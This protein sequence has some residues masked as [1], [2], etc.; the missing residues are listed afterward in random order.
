[1]CGSVQV[2]L[3][4]A[5]ILHA[6]WLTDF[7]TNKN[8]LDKI[9]TILYL[10]LS[11]WL[12]KIKGKWQFID[13]EGAVSRNTTQYTIFAAEHRQSTPNLFCRSTKDWHTCVQIYSK[14]DMQQRITSEKRKKRKKKKK[15]KKS[16]RTKYTLTASEEA[17]PVHTLNIFASQ[18]LILAFG[19][20]PPPPPHPC[21]HLHPPTSRSLSPKSTANENVLW[22]QPVIF[23]RCPIWIPPVML[24]FVATSKHLFW[25]RW[26]V[27]HAQVDCMRKRL[28]LA[29]NVCPPAH[30]YLG[31]TCVF[32]G[33]IYT[34]C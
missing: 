25:I 13:F 34:C 28:P 4:S 22:K 21:P 11:S 33:V 29:F 8:K 9:N 18:V 1:M 12:L 10:R 5:L 16:N 30:P 26:T 3:S 7:R 32:A 23:K 20:V 14:F 6:D 31:L 19:Q 27:S 24:A 17:V 15:V 2:I